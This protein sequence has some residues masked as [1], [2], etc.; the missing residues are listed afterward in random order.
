MH[1]EDHD[2]KPVHHADKV[3]ADHGQ[4]YAGQHGH[5]QHHRGERGLVVSRLR[6]AQRG[7]QHQQ[8]REE[9]FALSHA[10]LL[11]RFGTP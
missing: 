3:A 8:Q 6:V 5:R 4:R 9:G 1:R 10:M 2:G 11:G 7:Q